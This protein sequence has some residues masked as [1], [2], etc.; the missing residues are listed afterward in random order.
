[1]L[2][3]TPP[4]LLLLPPLSHPKRPSYHRRHRL[5]TRAAPGRSRRPSV[6]VGAGECACHCRRP[7]LGGVELGHHDRRRRRGLGQGA[8]GLWVHPCLPPPPRA[9]SDTGAIEGGAHPPYTSRGRGRGGGP[10]RR[11][12]RRRCVGRDRAGRARLLRWGCA[13]AMSSWSARGSHGNDPPRGQRTLGHRDAG[14]A[15]ISQLDVA[16]GVDQHI[17]RL[18]VA[19]HD[20]VA[21]RPHLVR[22]RASAWASVCLCVACLCIRVSLSLSL[23]VSNGRA[24]C[25]CRYSSASTTSAA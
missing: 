2:L 3:P 16:G 19:V 18:E 6:S 23:S 24:A 7:H 10:R 9:V 15:K 4:L 12:G 14:Q 8:K 11:R 5:R 17:V 25:L 13:G 22:G 1:M 20:P 21:V